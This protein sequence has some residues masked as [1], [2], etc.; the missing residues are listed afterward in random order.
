[1][2][3]WLLGWLIKWVIMWLRLSDWLNEWLS[4]W[5]NK[6]LSDWLNE[7][8][9]DWASEWVRKWMNEWVFFLKRT[10]KQLFSYIACLSV[11]EPSNIVLLLDAKAKPLVTSTEAACFTFYLR[12]LLLVYCEMTI[13]DCNSSILLSSVVIMFNGNVCCICDRDEICFVLNIGIRF[14]FIHQKVL[15]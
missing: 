12:V 2:S 9:S 15:S 13:N 6:W 3:E 11:E 4:D 5:L 8:L 14:Q 1:M 10:N 7:W